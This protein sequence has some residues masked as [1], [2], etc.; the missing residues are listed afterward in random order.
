VK[1]S[2]IVLAAVL[3]VS[4][5]W[6]A[7]DAAAGSAP[8]G[9]PLEP[10]RLR[11]LTVRG[12]WR[13]QVKRLTEHWVPHCIA[14]MEEGGRG[15]ELLNLVHAARVLK[16]RPAA[17]Y[18]GA[19]WSDAY[20]YNTI[21]AACYAV[22]FDPAGDRDLADAQ[23]FLRKK[24]D[25]WIPIV[26]AAQ[27]DDGYIHSF[28]TVNGRPRY[29]NTGHHEFYVQGYFLEAGVAHYRGTGGKDRRL[30]DAAV[31]CADHLCAT[32]GPPP[33]RTWIYGH[34]GMGLALGRLA[35][36]VD[37]VE[38][39]GKGRKYVDLAKYL[40]DHR[41][42]D[43]KHH[44]PYNQTHRPVVEMAHAVG[45]AVRATYFNGAVADLAMLTGD[46]AYRAAAD[47]LWTSATDRRMYVTGG[48]GSTGHGEAF[49][50][51]YDLPNETAYCESCAG[52]GL[53]FWADRMNRMRHDAACIDVAERVL[54]NNVL[55]AV[56][57]TGENFFYQNPLAGEQKRYPWHGCPCCVGN[58]PRALLAIKDRIYATSADRKAL[59][60]NHF[61]AGEATVPDLGG[62]AVRLV[63]ETEYPWKGEVVLRLHPET[64]AA[65]AVHLRIPDRG[66]SALYTPAPALAGRFTLEV[67]GEAQQAEVVRGYARVQRTWRAGDR[68]ALAL[69]I[70]VQRVRADER[71]EAD[72]GRVAL[73]YGPLVYGIEDV[74]HDGHCR[75]VVLAPEAPL[76]AAWKPDLL[77]GVMAVEQPGGRLVAI[78]NFVRL[79][80]GGWAQVWIPED[81][82]LAEARPEPTLAS[83]STVTT[84][85]RTHESRF[86]TR[87]IQDQKE[88]KRSDERGTPL[89]HWW[90][91]QGTREWVQYDFAEPAKASA[92]EVY[93]YDDRAWGNCREPESWRVLYRD[94]GAWKPVTGAS[95]YG[96]ARDRWHRVTFDPVTTDGLRLE[97]Q[98]RKGFAAGIL[99][100]RVE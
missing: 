43:P 13:D 35:R 42:T 16:G 38:G 52:C 2:G 14:Q 30:Y 79:N 28:H 84:S 64:P 89:L 82:A 97:V 7:A 72:R 92:V 18:T 32:F 61:V 10:V 87:A 76:R 29:S 65:F 81:P 9:P 100:W 44:N 70:E 74:D 68:I 80:R 78:P 54:Y 95:A 25:A 3:L 39:P 99:E 90:P 67:N 17:K 24:L 77:G 50:A 75:S 69:P 85:F 63:Q 15:Q 62:A 88:P 22:A 21:E 86:S 20:V 11:H 37:E 6:T 98:L 59:F 60:V 48:V 57:L 27:A 47:R 45:H 34:A 23:A 94:G 66:T 26:L 46:A 96:T 93:W 83:T 19:P 4:W 8:P 71:V 1:R 73:Q 40:F 49:G 12:F 51:D 55:G 91:H 5:G 56:E 53:A 58:I 36:L 41:H 33:R 31:R